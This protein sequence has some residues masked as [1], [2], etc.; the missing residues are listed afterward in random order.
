[1]EKFQKPRSYKNCNSSEFQPI[2]YSLWRNIYNY[3]LSFISQ[4][5][6]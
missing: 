2:E 5:V 3:L 4:K 1:M 6:I